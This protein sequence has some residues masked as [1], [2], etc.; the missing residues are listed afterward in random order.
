MRIAW[1]DVKID[2][3]ELLGKGG[4]GTVV[5]GLWRVSGHGIRKHLTFL[6]NRF[7]EHANH[8][9]IWCAQY[10]T[11]AKTALHL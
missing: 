1:K 2:E 5:K 8:V 7:D 10:R 11:G 3:S 4:Y 6:M 9:V